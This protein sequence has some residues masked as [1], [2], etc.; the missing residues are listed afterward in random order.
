MVNTIY[1]PPPLEKTTA[2]IEWVDVLKFICIICVY[3]SHISITPQS[4]L[5]FFSPFFLSAFFF[6]SGYTHNNTRTFSHF[7]VRKI[8]TLLLP[9]FIYS[10]LCTVLFNCL[11]FG[12]PNFL[13][14]LKDMF[15]QIRG[16]GDSLWFIACLFTSYIPFYFLS[17]YTKKLLGLCLSLILSFLSIL[18]VRFWGNVIPWHIQTVGVVMFFM[19][20]GYCFRDVE[21]V[22][23]NLLKKYWLLPVVGGIYT[24]LSWIGW[25]L[26]WRYININAYT[27][28]ISFWYLTVLVGLVL[29]VCCAKKMPGNP[30]FLFIGKNTLLCFAFLGITFTIFNTLL[31]QLGWDMFL[32]TDSFYS[33]LVAVILA[34]IEA[35]AMIPVI[36]LI[37]K[38]ASF[39]LGRF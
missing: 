31:A 36:C 34:V 25:Q 26:N 6:V 5:S 22:F 21:Q 10:F 35:I 29:I 30:F 12:W 32:T 15:L 14:Y 16:Q 3:L 4:L 18:S 1:T 20:L 37:Q 7:I 28:P 24:I 19:Y 33:T 17:K 2:R 23:D 39:T 8:K 9:W 13:L 38:K 11:L 27:C